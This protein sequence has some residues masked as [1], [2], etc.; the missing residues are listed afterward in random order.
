[1][2][3]VPNDPKQ[4]EKRSERNTLTAT[5]ADAKSGA[6]MDRRIEPRRNPAKLIVW[7][8]AALLIPLLAGLYWW[9]RANTRT[10]AVNNSHVSVSPVVRGTFD[11]F[12]PI[13]GRVTPRKTVY[14]DVIEGGQVQERFVEDGA[15]VE[16]GQLL[17]TLSNTALQ[18]DVTRN[19]AMVTEQ[20]NNMRTLELQLEQNRLRHK[21]DL[22]ETDYQ[23]TR[24]SR[25]VT[26][27][28]NLDNAGVAIKSQL[29][30]AEDELTYQRERRAV[31]L[32]SQQTDARLQ[33]TQLAFLK[34]TGER[35]Q[36]NLALVRANLDALNVRA[37]VS[38]KLSGL[39]VEV[40]QSVQRG[41]RLGQ[42]DDPDNNK[43]R[44]EAD[45][46]YLS[47]VGL[48]QPAH[49]ERN[50]QRYTLTVSK[51]YPQ[52]TNGQFELDLL[53]DGTEPDD[54]RRGQTLQGTLTLGASSSALLIPNGAFFQDTGGNWLFVVNS[55]GTEANRRNV[56]LGRRNSEH[57]EVLD[58][59]EAGE[60][61]VTSPYS[62]FKDMDRL[63]LT[64]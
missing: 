42:I 13:R 16:A 19:E 18:L 63:Q 54:I 45:E 37:P 20:L 7:G 43:L 29:E 36:S 61:V 59:L 53:F 30:D 12:I 62:S 26:R 15:S 56:R 57:I 2:R 4:N 38:G 6:G 9:D 33:E 34:E 24:L 64:D 22:V 23:I 31:T 3:A 5:S 46:F 21:R 40:G 14:L 25:L 55:A 60:R 47:R 41:G 48:G 35:L 1:M 44:V 8:A 49:V 58:G 28:S 17:V 32:V 50:G 10:F 51:I 11:D 27:L 39:E 52:V